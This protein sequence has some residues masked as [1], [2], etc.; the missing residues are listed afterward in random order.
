MFDR[1]AQGVVGD[2]F[3]ACL[4]DDEVRASRELFVVGDGGRSPVVLRRR[5]VDYSWDGVVILAGDQEERC[6]VVV[7]EVDARRS[8]RVEVGKRTLVENASGP[9]DRVPVI[10][11]DRVV[12]AHGV[13]NA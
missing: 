11:G 5:S 6:A 7:A 8:V 13:L 9:G 3:P 4:A 12:V 1:P 2:L 10:G